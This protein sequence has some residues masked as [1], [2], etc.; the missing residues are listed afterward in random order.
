MFWSLDASAEYVLI[1]LLGTALL[2]LCLRPPEGSTTG[3]EVE[4]TE[5]KAQPPRLFAIGLVVG[6]GLWVHQLFVVYLI[7]LG[8]TARMRSERCADGNSAR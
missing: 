4:R 2:L 6:L 7:P 8:D 5:Q 3:A 1:M